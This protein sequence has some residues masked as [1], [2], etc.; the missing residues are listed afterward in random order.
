[1]QET[2]KKDQWS[3]SLLIVCVIWYIIFF[4]KQIEVHITTGLNVFVVYL[5]IKYLKCNFDLIAAPESFK[6]E[7]K[8]I[9]TYGEM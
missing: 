9:I 5:L 2:D 4:Y 1:M 6:R 8:K 3:P 7:S